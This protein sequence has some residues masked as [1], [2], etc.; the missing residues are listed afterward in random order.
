M[1]NIGK[2]WPRMVLLI[3]PLG[4]IAVD[5]AV[6]TYEWL[7][8]DAEKAIRF[9]KESP[10]T[11][12]GFSVQQYLYTTVYHR[13][14]PGDRIEIEGWRA[15]PSSESQSIVTVRFSYSDTIGRHTAAWSVDVRSKKIVPTDET[16]RGLS[17]H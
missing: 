7:Q 6:L 15:E 14:T 2:T 9:V 11:K 17:W 16:A 4:I 12:E 1:K 8:T 3:L 5:A 10:S 13:K